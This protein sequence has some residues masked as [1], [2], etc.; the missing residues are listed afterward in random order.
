MP[1]SKEGLS[2]PPA[3]NRAARRAAKRRPGKQPGAEGNN[4][5]QVPNPDKVVPVTP[6]TCTGC[7]GDLSD[8]DVVDV[9]TRQVFELPEIRPYVTEYRI[10]RRRCR[11]GCEVK[12]TV[13]DQATAPACY[14]PGVR[15]L[16]VYLAIYQHLPY[17]RMAQLFSDV[18]GL[19]I[20]VGT[21][22][23]IVAEAG[24]KLGVFSDVVRDLLR[25]AP[26]VNFDETGARVEGKL[27]WVHVASS[28]LYTL[29]SAHERRGKVAMNDMGVI[30]NMVGIAQ[31]DGWKPYRS[32]GV[33]HALCNAHHK[34]ELDNLAPVVGQE[35]ADEMIG[36]LI[37]AKKATE[38][39][40]AKG[41]DHLDPS[42]LHSIRVRYGRLIQ[43]GRAANP[44][45]VAGKRY[46]YAKKAHNLL[47]R[48]DK[49]RAEVLRFAS[50]FRASWDN[51]QAER[52]VRMVKV[53]QKISG[54]WRSRAGAKNYCATMSYIS[55]MRKHGQPVL[56]GLRL[57]FEGGVW[58][59]TGLART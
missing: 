59:P 41:E 3:E 2:K 47:E 28:A 5:A 17:D 21:L 39:A 6:E 34:R 50:D 14:G 15:G 27:Q 22:T 45:P 12:G 38:E 29:L 24:G 55:T 49:R 7:G 57:L 33:V 13:P 46:G 16:A 53:Q 4:L 56:A 54:S 30:T 42:V 1:P 25:E 36:L 43:A 9:D 58:L 11:C 32:Y 40:K 8:A 51:N 23:A 26:L 31:H 35:W 52:D 44:P 10:E 20:S 18:F 19:P 37:E 48:L